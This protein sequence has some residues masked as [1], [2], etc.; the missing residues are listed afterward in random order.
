CRSALDA[1]E[2]AFEA[3]RRPR[4]P[5][6][7]EHLQLVDERDLPRLARLG[8]AASVQPAHLTADFELVERWWSGRR[9]RAYPYRAIADSGALM[10]FGSDGPVEP[11]EPAGWIHAALKRQRPDR[12]PAGGFVPAPHMQTGASRASSDQTPAR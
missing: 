3:L 11:P 1:F 6:R 9:G 2:A 4:L 7:L 8:I 10:A 5:S 12:R